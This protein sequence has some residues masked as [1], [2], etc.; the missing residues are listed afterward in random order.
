MP[1][2]SVEG[3]LNDEMSVRTGLRSVELARNQEEG[4]EGFQV[5]Y[6]GALDKGGRKD[7]L[8]GVFGN[9]SGKGYVLVTFEI[10][11]NS[12]EY[13]FDCLFDGHYNKDEEEPIPIKQ[14]H[15]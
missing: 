2:A 7:P 9:D 13:F 3:I 4:G 5:G 14:I 10:S 1:T 6:F 15:P 12:F 8:R 11:G